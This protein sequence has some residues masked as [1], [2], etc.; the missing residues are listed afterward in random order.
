MVFLAFSDSYGRWGKRWKIG[1]LNIENE[2]FTVRCAIASILSEIW[3][4]IHKVTCNQTICFDYRKIPQYILF[5]MLS[6]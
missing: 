6:R 5:V 1:K 4:Y 3:H 2:H